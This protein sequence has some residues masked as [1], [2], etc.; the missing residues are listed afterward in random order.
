MRGFEDTNLKDN[1]EIPN[2][3]PLTQIPIEINICEILKWWWC[4]PFALGLILSPPLAL[5]AKNGELD[6]PFSRFLPLWG[7]MLSPKW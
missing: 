1:F 2:E 5:I 7:L 6:S 3:I 4:G